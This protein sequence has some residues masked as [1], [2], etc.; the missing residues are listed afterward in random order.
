VFCAVIERL[1][2]AI[3]TTMIMRIMNVLEVKSRTFRCT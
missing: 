1:N 2:T 3:K